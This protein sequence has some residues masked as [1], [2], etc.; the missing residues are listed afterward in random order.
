MTTDTYITHRQEE[1]SRAFVHAVISSAGLRLQP[2]AMPDDDSVDL[3]ICARGPSGRVR[4]PKLDVQLKC[5]RGPMPEADFSYP[6][7]VKNYNDLCPPMAEFAVPRVLVL[8]AVPR[9]PTAWSRQT[10]IALLLRHRAFW[11]CLHGLPPST[12]TTTVSVAISLA[13][14]FTPTSLSQL[15]ERVGR[16]EPL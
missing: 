3:T 6:L 2:G 11:T 10:P 15:M 14:T 13:Q 12:N 1:F 7:E 16:R 5:M 4:S 8:V 9:D